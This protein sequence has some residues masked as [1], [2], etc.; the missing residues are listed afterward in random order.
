[1][2]AMTTRIRAGERCKAVDTIADAA[3][4]DY[5]VEK[6]RREREGSYV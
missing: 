3:V 6:M 5:P 1:M 2:A 4:R